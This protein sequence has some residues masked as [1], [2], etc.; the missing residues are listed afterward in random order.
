MDLDFNGGS[1]RSGGLTWAQQ[2]IYGFVYGDAHEQ[3][4][5]SPDLSIALEVPAGPPV[6]S[7]IQAL[8][9]VVLCHEALRTTFVADNGTFA[10]QQVHGEGRIPIRSCVADAGDI[11]RATEHLRTS[12]TELQLDV[13]TEFPLRVGLVEVRGTVMRILLVTSRMTVDGWGFQNLIQDLQ[14]ELYSTTA[15]STAGFHQIDQ[16]EWE[17]SKRGRHR[18]DAAA[19]YHR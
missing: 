8:R 7:C 4:Q 1:I 17:T 2:D 9:A 19:A 11:D 16:F 3:K 14:H 12:L 10:R 6:A 18:A 5:H 13:T 15:A